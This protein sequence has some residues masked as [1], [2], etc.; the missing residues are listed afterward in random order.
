MTYFII[1]PLNL[2]RRLVRE[3]DYPD[4]RA[5][6]KKFDPPERLCEQI[7]KLVFGVDVARLKVHFLQ[8]AS[9][10]VIPHPDVLASFMKNGVFA[11]ARA[12]LLSILSSTA[13]VSLPRRS[14][15]SRTSQST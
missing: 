9:D 11:R 6:L 12:D 14:S 15:S 7:C 2:I 10:E 1:L 3:L 8:V 4:P 5:K 13:P